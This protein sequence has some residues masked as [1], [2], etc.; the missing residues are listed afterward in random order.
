MKELPKIISHSEFQDLDTL[1]ETMCSIIIAQLQNM[2][3]GNISNILEPI[4]ILGT[5]SPKSHFPFK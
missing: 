3:A 2:T 4:H 5:A 1:A